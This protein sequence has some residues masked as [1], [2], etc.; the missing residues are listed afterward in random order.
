[1]KESCI[2]HI[3]S[4][5]NWQM[6]YPEVFPVLHLES[7]LSGIRSCADGRSGRPDLENLYRKLCSRIWSGSFDPAFP[8]SA[9]K[10]ENT[11]NV[12][13]VKSKT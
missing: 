3:L 13:T 12:R 11:G 6:Q 2:Q 7:S 10:E 4:S 5:V 9:W 1:M 8:V